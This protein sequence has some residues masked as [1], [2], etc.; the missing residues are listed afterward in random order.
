MERE[1]ERKYVVEYFSRLLAPQ[2]YL[3]DACLLARNPSLLHSSR[4]VRTQ[5][6]TASGGKE[7]PQSR[8]YLI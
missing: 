7:K 5:E 1:R 8:R 6:N 4:C 3:R 2:G